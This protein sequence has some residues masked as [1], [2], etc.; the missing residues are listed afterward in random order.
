MHK[1]INSSYQNAIKYTP[2]IGFGVAKRENNQAELLGLYPTADEAQKQAN[3]FSFVTVL[4]LEDTDYYST[5]TTTDY[6]RSQLMLAKRT[7]HLTKATKE[8]KSWVYIV[9]RFT[10]DVHYSF[11]G[12]NALLQAVVCRRDMS[13]LITEIIIP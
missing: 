6:L 10:R 4:T 8:V 12:D 7:G 13:L 11:I 3:S 2:V 1:A 9:N 5:R